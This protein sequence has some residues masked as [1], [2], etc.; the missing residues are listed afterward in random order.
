MSFSL[1]NF[2]SFSD[3]DSGG[4]YLSACGP[5]ARYHRKALGPLRT[6]G[7]SYSSHRRHRNRRAG[8]AAQDSYLCGAKGTMIAPRSARQQ[9][10]HEGGGNAERSEHRGQHGARGDVL[11]YAD[12]RVH[13]RM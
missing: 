2:E 4:E 13:F 6:L 11:D 10:H 5:S 3:S 9:M 12:P 1:T 7:T 8:H